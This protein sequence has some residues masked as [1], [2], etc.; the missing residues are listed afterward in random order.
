MPEGSP[1]RP[2]G[3]PDRRDQRPAL[4]ARTTR[5]PAATASARPRRAR[6]GA[7]PPTAW[8]LSKESDARGL[9]WSLLRRFRSVI[10][11]RLYAREHRAYELLDHRAA[12]R[13]GAR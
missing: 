4:A 5:T 3:R 13:R 10:E 9:A 1:P 12:A 7:P 8:T 11:A 6:G 2:P